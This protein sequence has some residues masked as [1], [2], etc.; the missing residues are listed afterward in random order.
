MKTMATVMK[1]FGSFIS[2]EECGAIMSPLFTED[3]EESLKKSGKLITWEDNQFTEMEQDKIVFDKELQEKLWKI[4]LD[5]C[6][7][8]KT[9]QIAEKY[10]GIYV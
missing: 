1:L 9:T 6:G 2:I 7:D 8:E 3:Q 10:T 4:S 5:L